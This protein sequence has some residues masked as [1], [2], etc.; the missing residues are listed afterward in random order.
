MEH[1]FYIIRWNRYKRRYGHAPSAVSA[2]ERKPGG[3]KVNG[4]FMV[5]R[6]CGHLTDESEK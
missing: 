2:N 6:F 4:L 5:A 3:L 1:D